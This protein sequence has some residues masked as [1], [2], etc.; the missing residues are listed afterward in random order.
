MLEMFDETGKSAL[1]SYVASGR[2]N[3]GVV[4]DPGDTLW[5]HGNLLGHSIAWDSASRKQYFPPGHYTAIFHWQHSLTGSADARANARLVDS[6][7]FV[8]VAPV[9]QEAQALRAYLELYSRYHPPQEWGEALWEYFLGHK[10]SP[11]G[12]AALKTLAILVSGGAV[13]PPGGRTRAQVVI[14]FATRC[15]NNPTLEDPLKRVAR[16]LSSEESKRFLSFLRDSIPGTLASKYASRL[17][18]SEE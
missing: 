9:G 5:G 12:E 2:S 16:E 11:Y 3:T 7:S 4:L 17:L 10:T 14:E 13:P 15:P 1:G 8:V 18:E 6:V